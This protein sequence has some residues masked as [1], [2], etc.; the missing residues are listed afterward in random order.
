M[1]KLVFCLAMS[2]YLLS[3]YLIDDSWKSGT[4][5]IVSK[6]MV[7]DYGDAGILIVTPEGRRE[8]PG[9]WGI[10]EGPPK[11]DTRLELIAD[12]GTV[13]VISSTDEYLNFKPGSSYFS[14]AWQADP[15]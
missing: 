6:R 4:K 15:Y 7:A 12:D 3:P 11:H 10:P 1:K 13:T 8:L 5:T 2:V 9:P 14:A